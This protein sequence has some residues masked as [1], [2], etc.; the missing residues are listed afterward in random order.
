[1]LPSIPAVNA[2]QSKS[3]ELNMKIQTLIHWDNLSE[4][5][6]LAVRGRVR[7]RCKRLSAC[8]S[9]L[10][11]VKVV[12]MQGDPPALGTRAALCRLQLRGRRHFH[13]DVDEAGG[14]LSQAL[15][16]AFDRVDGLVEQRRK[17]RRSRV[18]NRGELRG[19]RRRLSGME[20]RTSWRASIVPTEERG[21]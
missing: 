21:K 12:L 8:C 20:D 15:N 7:L 18:L 6:K 9:E 10:A 14:D 13:M 17:T 1:V 5:V 4:G 2:R 11:H 3:R 19:S 16:M